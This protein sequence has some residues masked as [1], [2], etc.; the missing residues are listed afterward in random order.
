MMHGC[1]TSS[2]QRAE[3]LTMLPACRAGDTKLA[4]LRGYLLLITHPYGVDRLPA[5]QAAQAEPWQWPGDAG[6]NPAA[7]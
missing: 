7:Q 4:S 6:R 2:C 1:H 3:R 5:M